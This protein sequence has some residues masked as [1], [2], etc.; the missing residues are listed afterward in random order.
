MLAKELAGGI[1]DEGV[2]HIVLQ[3]GCGGMAGAV[4][5]E[6]LRAA[7]HARIVIV[8]PERA[9][10]LQESARANEIVVVTGDLDTRMVGMSVGEVSRPMWPIIHAGAA[11]Y[12]SFGDQ[13][14]EEAM[15]LL[16]RPSD[17]SAPI[18]SGETGCAGLVALLELQS[19]P[20][21]RR[22]LALDDTSR[23]VLINTE[24]ATDPESYRRAMAG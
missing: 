5:P 9:A 21:A 19:D 23:V 3:A 7:P 18:E 8:E 17:D 12:V 1:A 10:C 2:T 20:D 15:R 14:V 11:G 22:A 6:L 13:Y 4:M 16:G 24:G